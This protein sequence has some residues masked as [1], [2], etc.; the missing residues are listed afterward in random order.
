MVMGN[1]LKLLQKRSRLLVVRVCVRLV[2][3][4]LLHVLIVVL[5]RAALGAVGHGGL[6]L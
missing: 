2:V 5:M 6:G 4:L 1:S 3:R